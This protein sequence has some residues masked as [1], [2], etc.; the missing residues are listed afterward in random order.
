M[1]ICGGQ[2]DAPRNTVPKT[3][4][5]TIVSDGGGK[6]HVVA[7]HAFASPSKYR[8]TVT[9]YDVGAEVAAT[10]LAT[11]GPAPL[12]EPSGLYPSWRRPVGT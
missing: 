10:G 1:T 11:I 4:V 6:F 7:S 2:R 3:T 9:I 8:V 5:G 12:D